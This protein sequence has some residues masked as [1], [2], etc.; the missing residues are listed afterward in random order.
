MNSAIFVRRCR[1]AAP[2]T[3]VF[4]WHASPGAFERLT[5]PWEN[6]TV[7]EH[8]GGIG[9]GARLTLEMPLGPFRQRWVAEHCDYQE[10]RQF[11]DVQRSGPFALWDHTHRM[12]PDGPDA[13]YLEDHIRYALPLGRLGHL[14]GNGLVRRKLGRLFTY[15]HRLTRQDV[16]TQAFY[17]EC[18]PMHIAV[19]G[20]TGVVGSAVVPFLTTGGHQVTRLVRTAPRPGHAEVQWEPQAAGLALAA[21]S[22]VDAVVHLAGDNIASGRWSAAKKARIRDSRIQGTQRLCAALARLPE[23]PRVLVCASA[24]GYYG[25]RGEDVLREDSAMGSGFLA[26]VCRDW[27]AATR[28]AS[29]A[30][31]RVVHLRCGIILS[32][33]GGALAKMLPPFMLGAG[34]VI[35]RGEQYMSW[36]ALDDVVGAIYHALCTESLQGP[37]NVVA[38]HPVT[39]RVFTQTL[40]RV[41]QRPTLFPLPALA[42]RLAFGEMA[43]ALLLA[44]TRVIPAQLLATHYRFRFPDL[45][46]ALRHILGKA[47]RRVA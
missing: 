7:V 44:S 24:I 36:I 31:I 3:Q 11:R 30:G 23:P 28:V 27:E 38:P 25:D 9:N 34:G 32:S 43:E 29:Q 37:V 1:I 39:N 10:G 40:G 22:G 46:D 6:V 41:L 13:C 45:E 21:L 14:L 35:G 20:A 5:P 15:R 19:S 47:E 16:E 18:T 42:A 12:E 4:R 33:Q 26:E 17:K 2:A 8:S